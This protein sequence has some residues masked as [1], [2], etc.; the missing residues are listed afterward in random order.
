[1]ECM[2]YERRI[3]WKMLNYLCEYKTIFTLDELYIRWGKK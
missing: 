2:L 3:S 1:M